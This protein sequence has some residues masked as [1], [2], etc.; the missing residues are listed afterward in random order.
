[1]GKLLELSPVLRCQVELDLPHATQWEQQPMRRSSPTSSAAEC[2]P[3]AGTRGRMADNRH[4][5]QPAGREC[6][7][8]RGQSRVCMARGRI[9][10]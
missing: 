4:S 6:A 5:A 1:M 9:A 3:H 8:R 7:E 2:G 10:G